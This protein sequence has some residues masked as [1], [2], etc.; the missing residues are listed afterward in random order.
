MMIILLFVKDLC[1]YF[2]RYSIGCNKIIELL[3]KI[4][5]LYTELLY[6]ENVK[7]I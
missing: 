7:L 2:E 6:I 3:C 4:E 1:K 5:L